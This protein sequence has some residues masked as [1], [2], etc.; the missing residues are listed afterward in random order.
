MK[1]KVLTVLGAVIGRL[2]SRKFLHR[3]LKKLLSLR[4]SCVMHGKWSCFSRETILRRIK[5]SQ[6][7]ANQLP[8]L[9]EH[10]DS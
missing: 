2:T 8:R 9:K 10:C 1:P 3:L 5:S 4:P 6:G 7:R